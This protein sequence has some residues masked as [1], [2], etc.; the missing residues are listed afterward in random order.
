MSEKKKLEPYA[1]WW[2]KEAAKERQ[3]DKFIP[4]NKILEIYPDP[5]PVRVVVKGKY[6][7]RELYRVS[8]NIGNVL[9]TPVQLI[10]VHERLAEVGFES[11]VQYP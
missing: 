9:L 1:E 6:G 8:T 7:D 10:E 2:A 4:K 3:K 11:P 5:A